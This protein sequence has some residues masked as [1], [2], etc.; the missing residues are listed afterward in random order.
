MAELEEP[1]M[2]VLVP[3]PDHDR[4]PLPEPLQGDVDEVPEGQREEDAGLEDPG[5][6]ERTTGGARAGESSDHRDRRAGEE[7]PERVRAGVPHEDAGRVEVVR[8]ESDARA[9][10]G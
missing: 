4:L 1:A 2:E 10:E 3:L 5:R 6:G 7:E 9:D 8:K